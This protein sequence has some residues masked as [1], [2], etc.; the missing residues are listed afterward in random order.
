MLV[1]I[2]RTT[3]RNCPNSGPSSV[4][5]ALPA[6]PFASTATMSFVDVSPSTLT[7]LNVSSAA[8]FNAFCSS[9]AEIAASVVRKPSI[10]AILG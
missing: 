8:S 5:G 4:I 1:Q 9:S 7:M 10:V 6:M 2:S 3:D